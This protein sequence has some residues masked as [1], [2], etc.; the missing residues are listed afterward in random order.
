VPFKARPE[1]VDQNAGRPEAGQ[2][3][4]R[5]RPELD[6]RPERHPFEV[7]AGGGDVLAELSRCNCEAGIREGR[8]ELG[9]DQ[10]NLPQIG[11][12]RLTTGE[13]AVPDERAG[14]GIPFDATAF[15]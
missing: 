9:W 6:Q 1:P 11:K 13:I 15:H 2:L 5:G 14:V 4:D 3:N 12:V 7:Q 8:E 10:V